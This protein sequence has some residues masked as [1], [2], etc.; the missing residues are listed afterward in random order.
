MDLSA[1]RQWSG[2]G[3]GG[4]ADEQREGGAITW[5]WT[6]RRARWSGEGGSLSS[7]AWDGFGEDEI[8]GERGA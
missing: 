7:A 8:E 1:T 5:I 3:G 6:G 2:D 4:D